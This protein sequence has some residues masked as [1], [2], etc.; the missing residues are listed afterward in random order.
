MDMAEF[1]NKIKFIQIYSTVHQMLVCENDFIL[2]IK[3]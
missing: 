1:Q 3:N 2:K